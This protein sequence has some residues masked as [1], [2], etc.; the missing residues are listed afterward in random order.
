M[1]DIDFYDL[2]VADR[3]ATAAAVTLVCLGAAG[4][5]AVFTYQLITAAIRAVGL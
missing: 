4:L 3:C 1:A 5:A 2:T